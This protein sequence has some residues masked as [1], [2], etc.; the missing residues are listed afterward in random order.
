M[1]VKQSHIPQMA[2]QDFTPENSIKKFYDGCDIFV[3]GG[4]GFVGRV[5]IEK[6]LRTCSGVKGIYV[7]IR[8]RK[9]CD[10]SSRLAELTNCKLFEILKQQDP[11]ALDKI[12]ALTGDV[13]AVRLGLSDED[14]ATVRK[15]SVIFHCAASVRFD[16]PFT[17]A[18]FMNTRGTL[19]VC[20]IAEQMDNLKVFVHVST[21]FIQPK[22][23]GSDEIFYPAD[24]DWRLFI[25]YAE[26]FSPDMLDA[27]EKK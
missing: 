24:V 27:L 4:T 23:H 16:D 18:L 14:L 2:A 15:C 1:T 20:K 11:A 19:E 6:L 5:L 13:K 26:T 21:S 3:T 8:P 9:G 17:S 12:H 10:P 22:L 25:K 7:L